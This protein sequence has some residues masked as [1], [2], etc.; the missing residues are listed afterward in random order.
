MK[1]KI[2]ITSTKGIAILLAVVVISA[3]VGAAVTIA[4]LGVSPIAPGAGTLTGAED[5][6]IESQELQYSGSDVTAVNVTMNNTGTTDHTVDLYV[7]LENTTSDTVVEEQTVTGVSVA[8]G[9]TNTTQVTL[10]NSVPV[11]EF[12]R[13]EVNAEQTG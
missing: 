12:D 2:V 9:S 5:L 4:T 3:S 11:S 10:P 13:V 7:A 6:S 8:A 1:D